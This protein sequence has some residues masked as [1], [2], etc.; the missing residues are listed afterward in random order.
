MTDQTKP[1]F[2]DL[3]VARGADTHMFL[4]DAKDDAECK[5]V[6]EWIQENLPVPSDADF[7]S[8]REY[9]TSDK[10]GVV[11]VE[12]DID[13]MREVDA[14]HLEK[15]MQDCPA[16]MRIYQA[17]MGLGGIVRFSDNYEPLDGLDQLDDNDPTATLH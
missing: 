12:F 3:E 1:E 17:M 5:R 2:N 15:W 4:W 13:E 9:Q 16:H 10:S 8:L 11:I 7:D 14:A 6:R